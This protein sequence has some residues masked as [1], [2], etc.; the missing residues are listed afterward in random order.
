MKKFSLVLAAA[1]AAVVVAL[2]MS[3]S[4]WAIAGEEERS[5]TILSE[6]RILMSSETKYG[7]LFTVSYKG[8][9]YQCKS[10]W[11]DSGSDFWCRKPEVR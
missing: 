5:H 7:H 1:A 8:K 9:I 6:G 3:G 4:G 10:N 11:Y 2:V